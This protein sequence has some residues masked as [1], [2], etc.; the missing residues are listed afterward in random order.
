MFV[1]SRTSLFIDREIDER[2]DGLV[3]VLIDL[4]GFDF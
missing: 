2:L 4:E 3:T 1:N